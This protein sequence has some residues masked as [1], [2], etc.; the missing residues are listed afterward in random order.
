MCGRDADQ[1]HRDAWRALAFASHG[2]GATS[3]LA[4][5][6]RPDRLEPRVRKRR[7][8]EYPLMTKPRRGFGGACG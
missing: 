3:V 7:P 1:L 8:K 6:D 4:N 5:P 2:Q